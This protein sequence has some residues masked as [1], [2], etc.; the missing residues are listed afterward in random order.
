MSEK[1]I[2][3]ITVEIG[4]D[5][6]NLQTKINEVEKHSKGLQS[7]LREVNSL[8][9]L[10]PTNTELVSQKQKLL[11]GVVENTKTKLEALRNAQSQVNEKVKTGDIS[12]EQYRSFQRDIIATEQ[13]L[14]KLE[15]QLQQTE[16]GL[17]D[18]CNSTNKA[19]QDIKSGTSELE[20]YNGSV[21]NLSGSLKNTG[22]AIAATGTAIVA[23]MVAVNKSTEEFRRDFSKLEQNAKTAGASIGDVESELKKLEA[24]TGETD[25]NI[26]ALSNLLKTGFTGNELTQVINELSGAIIQFPD[27]LKIESLSDSLQETIATSKGTGQFAELIERLGYN[28]DSFNENL[29]S[30]TTNT[31]KMQYVMSVLADSGLAEVNEEYV[32]SNEAIIE[33]SNSQYEMQKAMSEIAKQTTPLLSKAT[34][35]LAENISGLTEDVLPGLIDGMEWMLDNSDLIISGLVGIS[36]SMITSKAVTVT[37]ETVNAFKQLKSA[38]DAAKASQVALN[39]AQS[40]SPTGLIVGLIAGL[41]AG[42]VAYTVAAGTATSETK[43]LCDASKEL[44]NEIEATENTYKENSDAVR[45]EYESVSLL[46][47]SLYDL[48]DNEN[49][50]NDEKLQMVSLVKQLN[51]KMPELNLNIDKETGLLNLQKQEV[52]GLVQNLEELYLLQAEEKQIQDSASMYVKASDNL[53][54]LQKQK[55]TLEKEL[56]ELEDK[57][58]SKNTFSLENFFNFD[59]FFGFKETAL[60]GEI[61]VKLSEINRIEKEL[62]KAE[63]SANQA[64]NTYQ[65]KIKKVGEL[66]GEASSELEKTAEDMLSAEK[67]MSGITDT[68]I[69]EVEKGI[70]RETKSYEKSLD[71]TL[72]KVSD[73]YDSR[74]SI[75]KKSQ[76]EELRQF[77][78]GQKKETEALEAETEKQLDIIEDAYN[79]KISLIDSEFTERLKLIDEEKYRKIKS[80]NDEINALNAKTEAEDSALKVKEQA[81][82]KSELEQKIVNASTAEEKLEAQRELRDYEADIAR[83]RLQTERKLQ[84]SILEEQKEALE[85]A[86]D[87]KEEALKEE[88]KIAEEKAKEDYERSKERVKQEAEI[89]KEILEEKQYQDSQY[90][91]DKQEKE[92]A[93]LQ[94]AKEDAVE[95]QKETNTEL[96]EKFKEYQNDKLELAKQYY[97]DEKEAALETMRNNTYNSND[98][99]VDWTGNTKASNQSIIDYDELATTLVKA[100]KSSGIEISVGNQKVGKVISNWVERIIK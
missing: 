5:T 70:E 83:E 8:L 11:A 89:Q 52:Q 65:E 91:A 33:Y 74:I 95:K 37:L 98:Y 81:E 34:S 15:R 28:L 84:I 88:Q 16:T 78:K 36:A 27:T 63:E 53:S 39:L 17:N 51:N 69:S 72:D 47:D 54:A 18:F 82:K 61:D 13:K 45:A 40:A 76:K 9:K 73:S 99:L 31:E 87:E 75:L 6:S 80:I 1:K 30:C 97:E 85:T 48:A 23:S 19:S 24:I 77:E 14:S 92:F 49:L 46:V 79:K 38:T 32:K 43:R 7:E 2:S 56:S 66:S 94:K 71:T 58:K 4:G 68:L 12:E 41:T 96:L 42:I 93:A 64:Y 55:E 44:R 90:F 22:K 10:D 67:R 62:V 86:Y 3:G 21:E 29:E 35:I 20:K 57:W 50:S 59:D 100:I 25:S 60:S 26:E